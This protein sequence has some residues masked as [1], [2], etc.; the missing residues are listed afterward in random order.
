[1]ER[2]TAPNLIG[3]ECKSM[4]EVAA[5][6]QHAIDYS[7]QIPNNVNLSNDRTLQRALEQW[8]PRFLNW[9]NETGPADTSTLQVYLRTAI[10][11]DRDGW[12]NFGYVRMPEYRWGIFLAPQDAHRKIHFGDHKGQPVW[13]DVPGEY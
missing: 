7:Q 9:W 4:S 8:Q 5:V 1:M 6:T 10:S 12:A 2:E 13:Q 11:V 3:G